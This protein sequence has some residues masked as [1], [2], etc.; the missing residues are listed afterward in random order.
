[1]KFFTFPRGPIYKLVLN[2]KEFVTI[3]YCETLISSA[4]EFNKK[5]PFIT[6]NTDMGYSLE[7]ILLE[8]S[9]ESTLVCN[10]YRINESTSFASFCIALQDSDVAIKKFWSHQCDK[11]ELYNVHMPAAP[12]CCVAFFDYPK[13]LEEETWINTFI[14]SCSFAWLLINDIDILQYSC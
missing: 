8:K 12:C 6:A 3:G 1:V 14:R 5:V 13:T 4:L 11:H 10:I 9:N 2:E 7:C